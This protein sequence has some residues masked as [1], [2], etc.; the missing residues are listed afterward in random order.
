MIEAEKVERVEDLRNSLQEKEIL[1]KELS[2][3][4]LQLEQNVSFIVSK[5]DLGVWWVGD[6][7]MQTTLFQVGII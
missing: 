6:Q 2:E 4:L 5:D 3:K 1:N 7:S